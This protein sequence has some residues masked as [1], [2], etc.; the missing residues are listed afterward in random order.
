M[1]YKMEREMAGLGSKIDH[2]H[3]LV[4]QEMDDRFQAMEGQVNKKME[5]LRQVTLRLAD[6]IRAVG[7]KGDHQLSD[8]KTL[9][10]NKLKLVQKE[11][12]HRHIELQRVMESFE[13]RTEEERGKLVT[14][15]AADKNEVSEALV[16]TSAKVG[17]ALKDLL[18]QQV[19]KFEFVDRR[20]ID[21]SSM[22]TQFEQKFDIQS[23]KMARE[24]AEKNKA[25]LEVFEKSR[26][27]LAASI[28]EARTEAKAGTSLTI[29]QAKHLS[30]AMSANLKMTQEELIATAQ[31]LQTSFAQGIKQLTE[32]TAEKMEV[33][34]E[35]GDSHLKVL[36]EEIQQL[37]SELEVQINQNH[38]TFI[39]S[40]DGL[41]GTISA[42]QQVQEVSVRQLDNIQNALLPTLETKERVQ[43]LIGAQKQTVDIRLAGL[44]RDFGVQRT[45]IIATQTLLEQKISQ[46]GSIRRALDVLEADRTAKEATITNTNE[47]VQQI[48][49]QVEL[50][51]VQTDR[52]EETIELNME[53]LKDKMRTEKE[54]M[55]DNI[56]ALGETIHKVDEAMDSGHQ[57]AQNQG[58]FLHTKLEDIG[59]KIR[60][61]ETKIA[62]G[63]AVREGVAAGNEGP[64]TF[65]S[66]LER[67][68]MSLTGVKQW[69]QQLDTALNKMQ[70]E[71]RTNGYTAA[72][73]N[74]DTPVIG[75]ETMFDLQEAFKQEKAALVATVMDKIEAKLS[76][77]QAKVDGLKGEVVQTLLAHKKQIEATLSEALKVIDK[78]MTTERA[79]FHNEVAENVQFLVD[80]AVAAVT[81][82]KTLDKNEEQLVPQSLNRLVTI[83]APKSSLVKTPSQSKESIGGA[84]AEKISDE[85]L[86]I[87][88]VNDFDQRVNG[89]GRKSQDSISLVNPNVAN[90]QQLRNK[91]QTSM[92]MP[93]IAV[94]KQFSNLSSQG[95]RNSLLAPGK[96]PRWSG[97][98]D[99]GKS[100]SEGQNF[101]AR[102]SESLRPGQPK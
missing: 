75:E 34:E 9:F 43:E 42:L 90:G 40:V 67:V 74:N 59:E 2:K 39:E 23:E 41:Q 60:R 13:S 47:M 76:P 79:D 22:C 38:E 86:R 73:K 18:S 91:Q 21:F 81:S 93:N 30:E 27:A 36:R 44:E 101:D 37:T 96:Q 88:W 51:K 94:N 7:E 17:E 28:T 69:A 12:N 71:M 65:G 99:D 84:K 32:N 80:E 63:A 52:L 72:P 95:S 55:L 61:V 57:T 87:A 98:S 48:T 26:E 83:S 11:S 46:I 70:V 24:I 77:V 20:L 31:I 89:L 14:R 68:E 54:E 53:E 3:S 82:Q 25:L 6:T 5:T 85:N 102:P 58:E 56:Q 19:T 10:K 45:D 66:K 78:K 92:E 49:K 64:E 50:V 33:L 97:P 35:R 62:E 15:M 16:A 100:G 8:L 4:T 1:P 29:G